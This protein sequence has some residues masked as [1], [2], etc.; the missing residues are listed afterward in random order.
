MLD[1]E[2]SRTDPSHSDEEVEMGWRKR[3]SKE[4]GQVRGRG[5]FNFVDDSGVGEQLRHPDR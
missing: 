5:H 1:F 3:C 4:Y 2:L